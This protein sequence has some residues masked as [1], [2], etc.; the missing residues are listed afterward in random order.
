MIPHVISIDY[1]KCTA[2]KLCVKAC[3]VDVIVWDEDGKKPIAKYPEECATCAV[4][5]R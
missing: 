1:E 2:C 5:A 3:Y 4:G